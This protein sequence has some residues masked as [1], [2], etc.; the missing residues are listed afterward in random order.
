MIIDELNALGY[1]PEKLIAKSYGNVYALPEKKVILCELTDSYVPIGNFR[2]IF[3]E[4]GEYIKNGNIEKFIFDKRHLRTFHQP[5][6]EWYFIEWKTEM[7][8]S[9]LK[10]HR[11]LLPVGMP[12]FKNAVMAGRVQILKKYSDNII[13]KLDIKYS[14]TI[15]QAINE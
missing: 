3:L 10:T 12:W 14:Q 11:K 7:L 5:S 13:H 6:M 15:E 4:M 8:K 1:Q 2:T 9:G